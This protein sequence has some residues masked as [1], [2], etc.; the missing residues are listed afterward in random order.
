MPTPT[1][2]FLYNK[3]SPESL[4]TFLIF[5]F[6][7]FQPCNFIFEISDPLIAHAMIS[8]FL[9]DPHLSLLGSEL[10]F[11]S[12]KFRNSL[13]EPENLF[14]LFSDHSAHSIILNFV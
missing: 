13:F 10:A 8:L 11:A 7:V 14:L 12:D 1:V 3:Q 9:N 2:F 6:K 4:L 5:I